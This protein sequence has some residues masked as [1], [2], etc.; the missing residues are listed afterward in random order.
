MSFGKGLGYLKK[1]GLS[2]QKCIYLS[3][4]AF[5]IFHHEIWC[6]ENTQ[7]KK[8]QLDDLSK[9]NSHNQTSDKGNIVSSL[10]DTS[11]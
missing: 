7:N 6:R 1:I 2:Q 4:I 10:S 11:F 5:H 9:L 8:L 3:R